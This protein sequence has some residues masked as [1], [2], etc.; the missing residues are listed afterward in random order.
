[1]S[2]CSARWETRAGAKRS[3]GPF[4][5]GSWSAGS[6]RRA[7][8]G[9]RL[10]AI[11]QGRPLAAEIERLDCLLR[12]RY[13]AVA[14]EHSAGW[15]PVAEPPLA[16]GVDTEEPGDG[17]IRDGAGAGDPADVL[18]SLAPGHRACRDEAIEALVH[19]LVESIP[20]RMGQGRA[21]AVIMARYGLGGAGE[22]TLEAIGKRLDVTRE[23]IRQIQARALRQL[24]GDP[25]VQQR[26]RDALTHWLR[27]TV[28]ASSATGALLASRDLDALQDDRAQVDGWVELALDVAFPVAGAAKRA[29]QMMA[30]A[31]MALHR[32]APFGVSCWIADPQ[33]A[34][35]VFPTVEAW[36][37]ELEAD[38]LALPLPADTFASV[39]GVGVADVIA[40]ASAH[41]RFAVYAGYLFRGAA[42]TIDRRA[43]RAHLLARH[44]AG[45]NAISQYELW[46]E[47]RRRFDDIDPCSSNDLRLAISERQRGAPHLFIVDNNN[48]LFALGGAASI[49]GLDLAAR[50]PEPQDPGLEQAR[51]PLVDA[52]R[53]G[54]ESAEALADRLGLN[55]EGLLSQLGQRSDFIFVTPRFYGLADQLPRIAAL[56]WDPRVLIED[57]ALALIG[58]RQAH[59]EPRDVYVGWTPSYERALC[60]RAKDSQWTC[61]PQLLWACEPD[62]WPMAA[63]EK[64]AWIALKAEV[65]QPPAAVSLPTGSRLPDPE[66]LLRFLL[67]LDQ[68]GGLSMAMANR[69]TRPRG[70]LEQSNGTLLAMLARVGALRQDADT[71]WATHR[72]GAEAG[73]WCSMLAD[74]Y[75]Q[76]GK[77]AW[78]QGAC[79]AILRE[80]ASHP[81][82]GWAAAHGWTTRIC[83][84]A[85]GNGVDVDALEAT[86]PGVNESDEAHGAPTEGEDP[87]VATDLLPA[88]GDVPAVPADPSDGPG[89]S[90]EDAQH[91]DQLAQFVAEVAGMEGIGV[92]ATLPPAAPPSTVES[93]PALVAMAQ[94]GDAQA[95]YRLSRQL[96]EGVGT[97]PNPQAAAYWLQRAADARHVPACVRLGRRLLAGEIGGGSREE[98]QQ[99]LVY[100]NAGTKVGNPMACY[101]VGLAYRDGAL[102]RRNLAA[103]MR[104]LKR[105]ARAGHGRAAYALALMLSQRMGRWVPDTLGL[106]RLAAQKGVPEAG[107]LLDRV[108]QGV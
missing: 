95:Q 104:L 76:S 54:P 9:G 22:Q 67:V 30:L 35:V 4:A 21:R 70:P 50:F 10:I 3:T 64:A 71:Y 96:D 20:A 82:Q 49:H 75:L 92:E 36:I 56:E 14:V 90:I 97:A 45:R 46:K 79:L 53:Q 66:R 58:C 83:S 29:T 32:Y 68:R 59:E 5:S 23:L 37:E 40:V 41:P 103:S 44:L 17:A 69:V 7:G 89:V 99:G 98:R 15:D 24:A 72:A 86:G 47:Y 107:T 27:R 85:V 28:E 18:P 108:G 80:A 100:L 6:W 93:I 25:G 63:Q 105:A 31:D 38:A 19:R 11:V 74:E 34:S 1:M 91:A 26:A 52:L 94:S 33:R 51:G 55:T 60:V 88:G 43:V 73:R 48:S 106:L 62:R 84:W 57:D 61:L 39:L 87:D 102:T 101:L 81:G 78:T 65:A 2:R 77:L 12:E 42:A 8:D 13:D 16:D